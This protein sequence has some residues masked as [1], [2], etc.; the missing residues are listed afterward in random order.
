MTAAIVLPSL[1]DWTKGKLAALIEANTQ[2]KFDEVFDSF[3]AKEA[4][5]TFNGAHVSREEYKQRLQ[6]Q[7]ALNQQSA[8]VKFDAAVELPT[9]E[10]TGSKVSI[11]VFTPD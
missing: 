2:P 8:S 3:L 9:S 6:E 10:E 1:T 4:V 7:S 11:H 5:V